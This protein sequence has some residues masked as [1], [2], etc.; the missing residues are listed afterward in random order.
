MR[1]WRTKQENLWAE[2]FKV[3]RQREDALLLVDL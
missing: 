1:N 2:W 3:Q